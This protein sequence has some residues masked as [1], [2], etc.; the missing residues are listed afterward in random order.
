MCQHWR[1][2]CRRAIGIWL[3]EIITDLAVPHRA[4]H[5]P[6]DHQPGGDLE[7]GEDLEIGRPQRGKGLFHLY[8]VPG[9]GHFKGAKNDRLAS[10]ML[11]LGRDD[12]L[13]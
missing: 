13:T 7:F 6:I 1:H 8:C 10:I 11:A 5:L 2:E 12:L 4:D 3:I 9:H